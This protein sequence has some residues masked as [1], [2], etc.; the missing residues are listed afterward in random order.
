MCALS[1]PIPP[2][3]IGARL[4]RANWGLGALAQIGAH[5]RKRRDGLELGECFRSPSRPVRFRWSAWNLNSR[6][7]DCV[8]LLLIGYNHWYIRIT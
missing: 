4:R 7:G 8:S 1:P 2:C 6:H 5:W 3:H